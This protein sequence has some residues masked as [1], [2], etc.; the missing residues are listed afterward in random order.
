MEK[1]IY[2]FFIV[3]IGIL[4]TINYFTKETIAEDTV[5]IQ[6]SDDVVIVTNPKSP[7]SKNGLKI[8][9][10]FEED[11]TI[12]VVE[13]NENYMFGNRV[14]FNTDDKGN[15]YVTDW[16]RKRIQKYDLD[17]KYLLTIG[18]P[19]QGP[20]EFRNVWVP[21][22]DKEKK[23]YVTDIANYRVSFFDKDGKFL[24][25]IK[26][27]S[28]SASLYINSRGFFVTTQSTVAEGQIG[29]KYIS[30]FGL[31]DKEFNLVSEIHRDTWEPKPPSG[32]DE[33]SIAQG[34]ANTLSDMAFNPQITYFLTEDDSI[35]FGYPKKYEIHIYTPEGKLSKIIRREY[36]PIKVSKWHKE[37][38]IKN[39]AEDFLR[40]L[41]LRADS[42]KKKAIQLIKYPKYKPAY[43][44]FTLME[45]GWL[46]VIIDTLEDGEKLI[47]VFDQKG[48]YIAQFKTVIST[49]RLFFKN[50][51][52]YALAIENDYRFVKRYNFEIQEYKN[53]KWVIKK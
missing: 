41:P 20:G 10:V 13:G 37:N 51:K 19:G 2:S 1:K 50:G 43:Q 47:D 44:R 4:L 28:I 40:I 17:G 16:D 8:R 21:R 14:Y 36:E 42:I 52:A 33:N 23:I 45:N 34:L 24:R 48:K 46:I 6:K 39:Q 38:Y 11:L 9:I 35:Y 22:F 26:I 12:G 32:R 18:R 30:I 25:Q 27:P 7:V 29:R 53:K 15:F 5:K 31:Y 49:N 3:F